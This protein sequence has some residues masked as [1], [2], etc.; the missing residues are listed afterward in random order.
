MEAIPK[1]LKARLKELEA[2]AMTL[3]AET[4]ALPVANTSN[5]PKKI[6]FSLKTKLF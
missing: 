2:K 4:P 1:N 3:S 5:P 6:A